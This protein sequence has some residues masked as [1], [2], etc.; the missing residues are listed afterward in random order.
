MRE[1]DYPPL[2]LVP[3]A[4]RVPLPCKAQSVAEILDEALGHCPDKL[5]VIGR[6]HRLTYAELDQAVNAAAALLTRDYAVLRDERIACTAGN[7]PDI[8][9]AFL[10]TQRI[11][12][13]WVGVNRALAPPEKRFI[14]EDSGAVLYLAEPEALAQI[15]PFRHEL[16]GLRATIEMRPDGGGTFWDGLTRHGGAKRPQIAID[17]WAPAAIAYT[18]GTTGRPKGAVHSQHNMML[19]AEVQR[20]RWPGSSQA[21][22]GAPLPLTILNVIILDPLT[23]F[24]SCATLVAMDRIDVQGCVEWVRG[25][26]I[27]MCCIPPAVFFDFVA[28][29]AITQEDLSS[30]AYPRTGG[31][32]FPDDVARKY[33]ARY[34]RSVQMSYGQTEIPTA[35]TWTDWDGD[36]LPGASGRSEPQLRVLIVDEEDRALPPGE[37]G[38]V[39]VTA[40]ETGPYAGCY[41]PMLG[42][43][44]RPEATQKTLRNGL[45]H[46]GD[47]GMLDEAGNLFIRDRKNDLIIRGGSNVYPAEIERIVLRHKQVRGCAVIGR[48][49]PRL[50]ETVVGCLEFDESVG[51]PEPVIAELRQLCSAELAKYKVPEEWIVVDQMPRN[52]M[53][54]IVKP[55]LVARFF[56]KT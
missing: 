10:A 49:D 48:P 18:S 14:L 24:H 36:Y 25:E 17:P 22:R 56:G 41:T 9:I 35:A 31:G 50:G 33:R 1:D 43:W 16:A 8:L 34:G 39:A 42:Y 27:V 51:D 54:K 21:K 38:E 13:I 32:A 4:R 2:G 45:L 6:Y 29:P 28:N 26:R 3:P 40:A 30:F 23:S 37:I 12:A 47:L 11:G 20:T 44:K 53:Q 5:A 15:A 52:S 7:H 55:E 19:I 46:T